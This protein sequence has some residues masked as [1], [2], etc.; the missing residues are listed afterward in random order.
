MDAS[1]I[2]QKIE[3]GLPEAE[4]T[5]HSDDGH[6][7][8]ALIVY[9]GFRDK[10]LLERH[11]IVYDTLGDSFKTTLHALSLRTRTPEEG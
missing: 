2:Q 10:S 6:H 8:E 7:F 3:T 11:R 1:D 4:V 9:E 5:V